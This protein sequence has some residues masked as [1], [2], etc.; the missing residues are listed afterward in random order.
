MR[1]EAQDEFRGAAQARAWADRRLRCGPRPRRGLSMGPGSINGLR[2]AGAHHW[3]S[4]DTQSWAHWQYSAGPRLELGTISR[5]M[6]LA[7]AV[8]NGQN[9]LVMSNTGAAKQLRGPKHENWPVWR[10]ALG[11][12]ENR[13]LAPVATHHA[14]ARVNGAIDGPYFPPARHPN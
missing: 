5:T 8:S 13:C 2:R 14:L 6:A 12:G 11:G 10:Y 7:T 9:P 1:R 3:H 4:E